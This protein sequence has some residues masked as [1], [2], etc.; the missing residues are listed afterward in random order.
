MEGSGQASFNTEKFVECPHKPSTKLGSTIGVD[1]Q[2]YAVQSENLFVVQVSCSLSV[3]S[4][5]AE[6][7]VN[8]TR[9]M[10]YVDSDRVITS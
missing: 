9:V 10:V 4:R 5:F 1:F 8:L 3:D 7:T 2:R 6:N